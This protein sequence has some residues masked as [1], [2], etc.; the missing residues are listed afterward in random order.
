MA[1]FP[2]FHG[3]QLAANGFIEN[4]R[5]ERLSADPSPMSAGRLWY[6][7]TEKALKYSSL[8]ETGAVVIQTFGNVAYIDSQVAAEKAEREAADQGLDTRLASVE[9]DYASQSFVNTKIA[10][11]GSAFE[12][13]GTVDAGVS[14]AE[15]FDLSTLDQT[16]AGD[17]YKVTTAGWVKV[18][19]AAALYVNAKDGLLFNS[20][21]TVDKIDNTNSEVQG[22]AEFVE[23]TG[24][25]DTGFT[26]DLA[27]EFKARVADLESLLAQE[28]TDRQEADTALSGR[29]DDLESSVGGSTGDLAD[30]ATT[31]KDTLVG[32]INETDA[33]GKANATAIAAEK[34]RA[35]QAEADLSTAIGQAATDAA[36]ATSNLKGG[37]NGQRAT[38]QSDAAGLNHSFAHGLN[39]G[40]VSVQVWVEGSDGVYRNDIVALEETDVNTV[41]VGLTEAANVKVAVQSLTVLA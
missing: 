41:T 8:D 28:T 15:A 18:G 5:A 13:V 3:I 39:S 19:E 10:S 29:I 17:Y 38:Y 12:Y 23:V 7:T 11:L 27:P 30:L 26:V 2:K 33:A 24:S 40:F 25:P 36:Q 21:G 35:E 4:L 20:Q 1:N 32:A 6:N 31:N 34:T 14:E 37:I 16:E 9:S 22:T